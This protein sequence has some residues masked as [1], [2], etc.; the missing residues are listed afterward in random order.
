MSLPDGQ[1]VDLSRRGV[2]WRLVSGLAEARREQPPRP[3]DVHELVAV[4]WPGEAPTGESGINRVKVS[5]STLR[6]LGLRDV[7]VR[8]DGGYLFDPAVPIS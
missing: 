5:L 6:K 3:L 1:V 8:R 2:L 7:L 4:G